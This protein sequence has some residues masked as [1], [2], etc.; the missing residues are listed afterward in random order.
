[1]AQ[2]SEAACLLE[3][4]RLYKAR[5]L[6]RPSSGEPIF[7]GFKPG[8]FSIYVGD[9]PVYHFDLEGR[10]FKVFLD[11]GHYLK[12]ID[13][14]V[15]AVGRQRDGDGLT[16]TRRRLSWAEAT[17]VDARVRSAVLDLLSDLGAGRLGT[18][19][20]PTP[21]RRVELEE[22]RAFLERAAGWDAAAWFVQRERFAETYGPWPF[23]PPG[24]TAPVVVQATLGDASGLGFG[25]TPPVAYHARSP[26][27]LAVHVGEVARLMGRRTEMCR[28]VYLGGA[29]VL[30][31]PPGELRDCLETLAKVFPFQQDGASAG[32]D[33]VSVFVDR[34]DVGLPG[35]A[36]WPELRARGLKSVT[37]GV[38]SGSPEVR[39]LF[40]RTWTNDDL[41]RFVAGA[42]GDV[43]LALMVGAGG[44]EH[45]TDAAL[46]STVELVASLGLRSDRPIF[47][48]DPAEF[49]G[50]GPRPSPGDPERWWSLVGRLR[51]GL[52]SGRPRVVP[53]SRLK[54]PVP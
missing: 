13:N 44:E 34:F 54:Q 32:L 3:S 51:E 8:V 14:Q 41:R 19:E 33:G 9:A 47:A 6:L 48:L 25:G 28:E 29:D 24:A 7:V 11:G 17:D 31:R 30:S 22:L 16:L 20:P 40:G 38:E 10:W 53:Y 36:D 42:D 50:A 5:L 12:G 37:I 1:M 52:G 45:D 43:D 35:P 39:A 4:G 49:G 23:L 27:E 26:D 15:Q 18:A 2:T 21:V 46:R